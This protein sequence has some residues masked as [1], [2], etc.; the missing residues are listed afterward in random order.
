MTYRLDTNK[1]GR[2]I[3]ALV[4]LDELRELATAQGQPDTFEI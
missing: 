4:T 3:N 1:Y 2:S